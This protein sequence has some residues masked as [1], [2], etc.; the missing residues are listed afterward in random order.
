MSSGGEYCSK[1]GTYL[2]R[3]IKM[4]KKTKK[5]ISATKKN[6]SNKPAEA[7]YD[8]AQDNIPT[9]VLGSYTGTP[10]DGLQP[11]QDADDL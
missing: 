10:V 6:V 3:V 2:F 5:K 9:D 7:W 8:A 1:N 11:V 4:E